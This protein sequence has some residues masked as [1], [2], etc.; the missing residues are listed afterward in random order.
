VIECEPNARVEID[1]LATPVAP[2]A[3]DPSVVAPLLN[4]TVPVGTCVPATGTTVAVNLIAVPTGADD[5]F[6]VSV[7]LV[8]SGVPVPDK[9]M[10]AKLGV[11]LPV[12]LNRAVAAPGAGGRNVTLIVHVDAAAIAT[13]QSLELEN[14]AASAP[15]KV[16]A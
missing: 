8:V 15:V 6:A 12:M 10:D 13:S 11:T 7:D 14:D 4:V 3:L 16:I 1:K 9:S 2:S 5:G